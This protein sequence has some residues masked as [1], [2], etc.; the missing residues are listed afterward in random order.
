MNKIQQFVIWAICSMTI[1]SQSS[2]AQVL[3]SE[4]FE[5][6][7]G[8]MPS[9]LTIIDNDGNANANVAT[10]DQWTLSGSTETGA[11][12]DSVAA[13]TSWLDPAGASDDWLIT[14][15]VSGITSATSLAWEAVARDPN[16]AD[17]YEVWVTSTI[18]GASP[19]ISDF[20][21][22]GTMVFNIAAED[23]SFVSH[24]I[25][26][27]SFAGQSIYVGFRNNSFDKFILE[28]DDIVIENNATVTLSTTNTTTNASCNGS[29]G[30]ATSNPSG[31]IAPYSFLWDANAN[32]QTTA[33]A[34]GLAAGTYMF[35][36]TDANGASDTSSV[37]I[38]SDGVVIYSEDFE[39]TGGVM[40]S[41]LT[42]IDNDGNANANV[43]TFD[44]WTLSGST[45]TGAIVDSVAAV[46]S[47][48]DP[49]GT[50]DDWLI[51][52][53]ISGVVSGANL[54][55]EAVARDP[56]FAD[57]YEVWVTSTIAGASPVISDF[58]TGGTMVFNIA[59]EDTSFVSRTV[60]LTAFAGQDIYVAFRNN[61]SDKFI[62]EID[63]IVVANPCVTVQLT[64]TNTTTDASCGGTDGTATSVPS[65][66]AA[67]YT[68][69]WDANAGN[70]TTATA[71][72]LAAG[73]YMFTYTDA[74]GISATSSVVI[75]NP[76]APV[77]SASVTSNYNG[78]DISCNGLSDGEA[79]V[80]A[81]G[82]T[83]VYTYQW[84]ANANNQTTATATGLSA[85]MYMVT[86]TDA[87]SCLTIDTVV[88]TEPGVL[89]ASIGTPVNVSCNGGN[90]G[91]ITTSVSGGTSP[92]I[93]AWSNS[94]TTSDL[95]GL[96][97]GTYSGTITDANGC[98][99]VAG[100]TITEPML[101][102]A[103]ILDNG[104]GTATAS[105]TGGVGGY[106]YQ[107]D[108][109]A[110]NQ[111]T[112][113]AT[114]LTNNTTYGVTVTDANGCTSDTTVTVTIVGVEGIANL[115]NLS[116]YP[117]PANANVFVDLDLEKSSDVTIRV[118]NTMGQTVLEKQLGTV[119][120]RRI[121]LSTKDLTTGVYMVQ[122]VIGEQSITER[123]VVNKK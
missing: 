75:S 53:Q 87:L 10:F 71:T 41:G 45:E 20:T 123:L 70:Q 81:T 8:V 88:V 47:W 122:F 58:T 107:W 14:P 103:F 104:D 22:G 115:N 99:D 43:A 15:Q 9:G 116:M 98:T 62:L 97:A 11:V 38:A 111:T 60:S 64:T 1:F 23:T 106:T 80:T 37:V 3:Y 18:A 79:T 30:T 50:S 61:S 17:G 65:G 83:G 73:T 19:V 95:L 74:N 59:A 108:A 51:T 117:N 31:G 4:D 93:Y 48:L 16:F 27:S 57:G 32:N 78:A 112:A 42:I 33:T 7:G 28:I 44:Q 6:T 68:F 120:S 101:L 69:L 85:G 2:Q 89:V 105:A 49:A 86:T 113:T 5:G 114:G 109:A 121:E 91:S 94:A 39:G 84:D 29:D 36:Y 100:G 26:L 110:N 21:T 56:S 63:D 72:G 119:V 40:P 13:V 118:M 46:T 34:T 24:M 35:T 25:S 90:D 77:G 82:G 92:Y 66:G 52:P 55:W 54:S 96:S 76:N 102:V 67:P 12:V